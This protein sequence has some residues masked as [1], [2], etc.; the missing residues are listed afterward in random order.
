MQRNGLMDSRVRF[1][2][3]AINGARLSY[4][5]NAFDGTGMGY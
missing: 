4:F 1:D 2:V 3:C 5:R